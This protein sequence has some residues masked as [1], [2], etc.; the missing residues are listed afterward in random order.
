[1]QELLFEYAT[2]GIGEALVEG[3]SR[4]KRCTNEGR[5]LMSLDL[6]VL[7]NGL[8]NLSPT[9]TKPNMQ[10]VDNYIKVRPGKIL[11]PLS[12]LH[13]GSVVAIGFSCLFLSVHSFRLQ[14][15]LL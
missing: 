1:M 6:Q 10:I 14:S 8:Q 5:A 12:Q 9:K 2:D 7:L 4:V 13:A 3:F 15:N 11:D